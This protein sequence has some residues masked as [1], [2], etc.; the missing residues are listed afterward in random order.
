MAVN[1]IKMESLIV[2]LKDKQQLDAVEAALKALDVNFER[3]PES[4]YD[5]K[6]VA[7]I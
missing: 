1:M 6:F 2:H 5:P 3:A 7:E 4:T